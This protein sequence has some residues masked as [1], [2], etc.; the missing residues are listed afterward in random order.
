MSAKSSHRAGTGR[1]L[2]VPLRT[3][4][5]R[6]AASQRWLARH[7]NDPYVQQA[8]RE[9]WR[10]RAAFKLL[11]LDD[12]FGLIRRGAR[13]LDLGAAPGG[14]TQVALARGA[15]AVVG[16]DLLAVEPLRGATFLQGDFTDPAV[17]ESALALLGGKADLL[18][19]DVAPNTTGHS[20]TDHLR[21]VALAEQ[22]F[23]FAEA[24]LAEGGGFVAKVFQGGAERSLLESMKCRFSQDTSRQTASQPK[25]IERTLH[26]G[27]RVSALVPAA[28]SRFSLPPA[29]SSRIAAA[30]CFRPK[31][32]PTAGHRAWPRLGLVERNRR[33]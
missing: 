17:Q 21:I 26:R 32:A 19:S 33:S 11:E 4:R 28:R 14:W 7:L 12:R 2:T 6:S 13:V 25:G 10:S 8:K 16:I 3:G 18:L 30:R 5:G 31:A 24:A 20:A 1:G 15:D 23:V 29:A 22:A 9:G 27:D